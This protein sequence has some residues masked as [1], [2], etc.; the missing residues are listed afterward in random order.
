MIRNK[1]RIIV[2]V[3]ATVEMMPYDLNK[4]STLFHYKSR[5]HTRLW[6]RS[7]RATDAHLL[8]PLLASIGRLILDHR[9]P[10]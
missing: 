5:S 10:F 8:V 3:E 9:G 4:G 1:I 2:G 6:S 7:R